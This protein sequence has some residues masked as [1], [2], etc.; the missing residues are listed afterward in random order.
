MRTDYRLHRDPAVQAKLQVMLEAEASDTTARLKLPME[1]ERAGL[2]DTDITEAIVELQQLKFTQQAALEVRG[3]M[4]K[5][6][7]FDYIG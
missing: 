1:T 4:P 3:K 2:E 7:L 5:V 6:S